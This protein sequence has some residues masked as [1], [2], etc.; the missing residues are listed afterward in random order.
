MPPFYQRRWRSWRNRNYSRR[1]FRRGRF[2]KYFQRRKQRS[3]RRRVRRKRL[4]FFRKYKKRK[5]TIEQWQPTHIKKCHIRGIIPLFQA[6]HGRF[7]NDWTSYKESYV[8]EFWPGG[9]GWSIFYLSLNNLFSENQKL[10]NWWTKSNVGLPLC[11]FLK[12]KVR[13]YRQPETDYVVTYTTEHPFEISKFHFASSHP[14]RLL[15][16]NH[17]TIV[18]SL[19]TAPHKK[20]PY[21]TKVIRPP[22][23]MIDKWY[24]QQHFARFGLV[25]F[26]AAACSLDSMFIASNVESN[27]ITLHCLN[28]KLFTKKNFQYHTKTNG[29]SPNGTSYLYATYN[30]SPEPLKS[31]YKDIIYLGNAMDYR[32]GETYTKNNY[33]DTKW[34]NPFYE[35]YLQRQQNILLSNKQV[36]ALPNPD[37][38]IDGFT[39]VDNPFIYEVRYNP[40]KD[41]GIGNEAYWVDN[42]QAGQGWG[43]PANPDL[44][45]QGFPL[46]ILLWGWE[47]Y[48]K[49][50]GKLQH[51]DHDYILVVKSDFL[52][53]KLPYYIFLNKSF[54]EGEGRYNLNKDYVSPEERK[55][56]Y[57]KWYYQKEEIENLLM[58]GPSVC[59]AETVKQ[60][61]AH[62]GYDFFFKWGGDP[63]AM[64]KVADPFSQPTFPLPDKQLQE[65]E[66]SNPEQSIYQNIYSFDVRRHLITQQAA[67]RIK[68]DST[69][70]YSLFTDGISTSRQS[71][72]QVPLKETETSQEEQTEEETEASLLQQLLLCK[73][74]NQQLS[75]RFRQLQQLIQNTKY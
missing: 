35:T 73:Q 27:N 51:L 37:D 65:Y 42:L 1:R 24:F 34:G 36:S 11:R 8:P 57:P 28:T 25:Q 64:E 72:L 12:L 56:W 63:A 71:T 16:Y 60:I 49:R 30:G 75:N 43:V 53:E 62:M 22:R 23:Q 50:T 33:D 10:Q 44:H 17:K 39:T 32:Q 21:I 54:T 59:K 4:R 7:S 41:T 58:T 13:F 15:M 40:F 47:D 55:H 20:K 6:G 19:K 18:P 68:K 67:T 45:I 48:S 74:H 26:T 2:R 70:D 69:N 38:Q 31:K 14:Q 66:I 29:Y 3:R 9:G 61:Q 5:I 46:W 52:S